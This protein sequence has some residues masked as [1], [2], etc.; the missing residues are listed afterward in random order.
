M[1]LPQKWTKNEMAG[2]TQYKIIA[3]EIFENFFESFRKNVFYWYFDLV[4]SKKVI[5]F[6][7][8][9]RRQNGSK[10]KFNSFTKLNIS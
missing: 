8:R 7:Y 6:K 10:L 1:Q 9:L 4:I 3:F 5:I 2:T